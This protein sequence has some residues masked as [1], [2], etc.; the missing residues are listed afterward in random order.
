M[1]LLHRGQ[2]R[3]S[4]RLLLHLAT[5]KSHG[6]LCAR[7]QF[8]PFDPKRQSSVPESILG[9]GL[10]IQLGGRD[11]EVFS[12][13]FLD[14]RRRLIEY[15]ELFRGTIDIAAVYPREVV[16]EALARNAAGVNSYTTILLVLLSRPKRTSRLRGG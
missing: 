1:L 9:S 3:L 15:C 13:L 4:L 11:H 7:V 2:R 8:R 14:S 10:K 12:I 6:P 16:K 5:P